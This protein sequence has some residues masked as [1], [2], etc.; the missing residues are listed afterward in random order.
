MP[1]IYFNNIAVSFSN[2][3]S[4]AKNIAVLNIFD[5]T[6]ILEELLID[7]YDCDINLYGYNADA[8]FSDFCSKFKYIEAAGGIVINEKSEYLLIKRLG[9]WDL[10]KGKIEKNEKIKDAAIREVCEETG[11]PSAKITD[12]LPSTYHIYK[13]K[14]K[15][16]LKKTYWF[17]MSSNEFLNLVPQTNEDITDAVWMKKHEANIALSKSY[18]SLFDVLGYIFS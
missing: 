7:E 12:D 17:L 6:K 14:K 16:V 1:I 5:T 18:R 15:F 3:K 8:I 2:N 4:A 9:I 13:H 11:L 10:P